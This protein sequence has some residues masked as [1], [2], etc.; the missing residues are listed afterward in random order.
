MTI[1]QRKKTKEAITCSHPEHWFDENEEYCRCGEYKSN[2]LRSGTRDSIV[3]R[4]IF[5]LIKGENDFGDFSRWL[6][7]RIYKNRIG[8]RRFFILDWWKLYFGKD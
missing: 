8:L 1:K 4:P 5:G 7:L 6:F 3:D 2:W